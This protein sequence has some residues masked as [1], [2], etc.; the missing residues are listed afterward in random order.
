M[1]VLTEYENKDWFLAADSTPAS[2]KTVDF[3]LYDYTVAAL[4]TSIG[5]DNLVVGAHSMTV[6]AA[7]WDELEFIDHVSK[8]V[9]F[10]T[11]KIG[12]QLYGLHGK[13]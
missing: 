9:N 10:K 6:T 13:F 4:Q 1:G 3:K 5:A 11:G 2:T 12:T 7:L 8:G